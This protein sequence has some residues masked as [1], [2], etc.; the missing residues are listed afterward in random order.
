MHYLTLKT[1]LPILNE[2]KPELGWI[3]SNLKEFYCI[4]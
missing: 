4:C 2:R 3:T 1:E